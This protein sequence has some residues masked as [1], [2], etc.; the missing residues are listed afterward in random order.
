MKSKIIRYTIV[1]SVVLAAS[2][3]AVSPILFPRSIEAII[4]APIEVVRAPIDGRV[5]AR[6][7]RAG[8]FLASGTRVAS[9]ANERVDEKF[10]LEMNNSIVASRAEMLSLDN[11]ILRLKSQL[12][13]L[14]DLIAMSSGSAVERLQSQYRQKQ[15]DAA[16]L[17]TERDLLIEEAQRAERLA[18]QQIKSGSEAIRARREADIAAFRTEIAREEAAELLLRIEAV[19]ARLITDFDSSMSSLRIRESEMTERLEE[20][21]N[22]RDAVALS[23]AQFE[24]SARAEALRTERLRQVELTAPVGGRVWQIAMTD[25]EFV[26]EGDTLIEVA[27]CAAE[28]VTATVTERIFN[29]IRVGQ[30][31]DF[32]AESDRIRRPGVIIQASGPASRVDEVRYA[33]RSSA[34]EKKEF[35]IAVRLDQAENDPD[36]CSI[37]RTGKILFRSRLGDEVE[38]LSVAIKGWIGKMWLTTAQAFPLVQE[39]NFPADHAT[40]TPDASR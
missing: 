20:K 28:V 7:V 29:T 18:H 21:R 8:E 1:W 27:N 11:Q 36:V 34:N 35:R 4:N 26:Q 32:V 3:F 38:L 13:D 24:K 6:S 14:R 30:P 15:I 33:I 10:L 23:V 40:G 2:Y 5:S 12:D 19:K 16:A 22:E 25:S 39:G 37:G 31:I 17:A 9:I